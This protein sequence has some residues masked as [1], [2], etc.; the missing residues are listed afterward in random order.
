[1]GR[2]H[3]LWWKYSLFTVPEN[4]DGFTFFT[5][6]HY[7]YKRFPLQWKIFKAAAK[8]G[9]NLQLHGKLIPTFL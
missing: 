7:I 2:C 5:Q 9:I 3:R 1:M 4:S 8:S 6:S